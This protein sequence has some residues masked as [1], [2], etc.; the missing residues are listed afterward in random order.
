MKVIAQNRPT[1]PFQVFGNVIKMVAGPPGLVSDGVYPLSDVIRRDLKLLLSCSMSQ[2]RW[3][4]ETECRWNI[5]D[6]Y[7]TR[8]L[9]SPGR[10]G[11]SRGRVNS[12]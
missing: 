11:T 12:G 1:S 2:P 9:P 8:I 7:P 5:A 10:E 3:V 4:L 6:T